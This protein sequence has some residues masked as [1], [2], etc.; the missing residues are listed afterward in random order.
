[1]TTGVRKARDL[2]QRLS[3][4]GRWL[5][6]HVRILAA[7]VVI[8]GVYFS[9]AVS[10]LDDALSSVRLSLVRR[11]DTG[12]VAVVGIDAPSVA[13]AGIWPWP[14][15]RFARAI[16]NL[17]SAGAQLIA[18]DVDFSASS[19]A[20]GDAALQAAI[21]AQAGW[22]I[23]PTFVQRDSRFENFPLASIAE[24]AVVGSVNVNLDSD[25]KVR[26]YARGY[27]HADH[28]HPTV[29]AILA[30]APYGDASSFLVD[31]GIRTDG[32]PRLSFEDVFIG[33]F[34]P[35]LVRG[36]NVLI[37]ATAEE[38]GDEYSTP[39]T[40]AMPGVMVHA[41]A[42]ESLVQGR[43]LVTPS[44]AITFGLA[45]VA[46]L[47]L[48]PRAGAVELSRLA[49]RHAAVLSASLLGP[50]ALQ[51]LTPVSADL[52]LVFVA[53]ALC[54]VEGVRRELYRRTQEIARQREEH[55]TYIAMHDPETQL[56]NRRAMQQ[57]LAARLAG[58]GDQT[59]LAIAIGI[60]KFHTLRGAIGYA[61]AN[62]LVAELAKRIGALEGAGRV[63]HLSTSILGVLVDVDDAS[64]AV[65]T[66][67]ER[68]ASLDTRISVDGQEID[69][70]IR[71]GLA[72]TETSIEEPDRILERATIALDQ[73]R[74][75][76]LSTFVDTLDA[77]TNPKLQLAMVGG[78]QR[79]IDAGQF[80]VVYQPKVSSRQLTITGAEAL[81]R[82]THPDF[83]PISPAHF[84]GVMEETG[85][86]DALSRWILAQ[87]IR[88]QCELKRAGMDIPISVN[89]S[90]RL[91]SDSGFCDFAAAMVSAA[92][93]TICM[94]ITETAMLDNPAS[95]LAA[96]DRLR[97]VGITIS[98]DDYGAGLSSLIYLKQIPADELKIDRSLILDVTRSV[99]DRMIIKSTTDLAHS[100]GMKVVAEGVEDAES[101]SVLASLGCDGLQGYHIGRPAPLAQLLAWGAASG[102]PALSAGAAAG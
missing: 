91:L 80:A 62:Q 60:D 74:I 7:L 17:R 12:T 100:L 33:R 94:E 52:G 3:T 29:A 31:Y 25:G 71:T 14:R 19:T 102:S 26:S 6:R 72:S 69:V 81:V 83:G 28:Y 84:I 21:D 49:L 92:G 55:L 35:G 45:V 8:S 70:A 54:I 27:T 1:M 63:F 101:C 44:S 73:A 43:T 36:R 41:L 18:F 53:Q 46:L 77:T 88:D 23:L 47:L 42:Y 20:S 16:E 78:V 37:G 48:W 9:G 50:L 79:G 86:I 57:Q 10:P 98:I 64:K 59:S 76:K 32:I 11:A 34:D 2:L 90:A 38:L 58:K 51:A 87:V 15:E 82:W 40:T 13:S 66:W 96:I 99:R 95:A 24:N 56:P 65:R 93:A 75:R 61:S 97:A 4:P 30:N 5:G 85:A 68:V 67:A 39:T 22:I 89:L